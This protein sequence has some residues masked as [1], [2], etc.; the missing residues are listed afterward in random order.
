[1]PVTET[2]IQDMIGQIRAALAAD[3]RDDAACLLLK[4]HVADQAALFELLDPEERRRLM[5]GLGA[6]DAADLLERVE[7]ETALAAAETMSVDRLADVLDEMEPDEAADVLG[8]LPAKRAS[9]ALA[10]MED[11]TSVQPLLA[12]KDDS[13]GGL[14]T[15]SFLALRGHDS[16]GDATEYLRRVPTDDE[17]PYYLYVV[18]DNRR[19]V[20]VLSLRQLLVAEPGVRLATLMD[21]DVIHVRDVVDQEEAALVMG[22]Y[23]LAALP[24]V[25]S[26]GKL[27]GEITHD[28]SLDVVETEATEDVYRLANVADSHLEPDSAVFAQVRGRLPWLYINTCTALLAAFVISRFEDIIRQV[29]ALAVFQAVVAGQGGNAASQNVAMIVRSLVTGKVERGETMRILTRQLAVGVIQGVCVGTVVGIGAWLWRGNPY[30]G[31]IIGIALLGN[32]MVAAVAGVLVP[33]GLR[34]C[35]Q[36]PAIA[37]SVLVTTATDC[38][39]FLIFLSLAASMVHHLL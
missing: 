34:A 1:M 35:G 20:G 3:R 4:L 7:D 9:E 16:V 24:V 36:D 30:L 38:L 29:T 19:L 23:D 27:V 28:D 32:M 2:D 31:L 37:S 26:D 17:V 8:D 12:Y 13:A 21:Q 6:T 10:Q 11:A 14:M 22:R 15:T 33:L 39:G 25:N 5:P 18:D